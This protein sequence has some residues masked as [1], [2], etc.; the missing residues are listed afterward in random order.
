MGGSGLDRF[1]L[2]AEPEYLCA[3][4]VLVRGKFLVLFGN[5]HSF[6]CAI[7]YTS[8]ADTD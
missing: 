5:S 6:A 3:E 2:E 1:V 4:N 7:R 8:P